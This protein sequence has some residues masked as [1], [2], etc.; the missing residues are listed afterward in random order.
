[1]DSGLQRS[2]DYFIGKTKRL[3]SEDEESKPQRRRDAKK[4]K[5]ASTGKEDEQNDRARQ[6]INAG[7]GS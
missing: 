2:T 1:V 7:W 3:N 6:A 5:S 4:R